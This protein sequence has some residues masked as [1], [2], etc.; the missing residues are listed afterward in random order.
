MTGKDEYYNKAK[1]E[2]YRARSAYKLKQLDEEAGLFGP[3]NTVVDL[4]AAPGGWL[5][6]ASEAVGERGTVVGV[7]FQRI[8]D[9]GLEN[10]ETIRGDM[11]DEDTKAELKE[12]IGEDGADVVVSDM[13]PNMTG[14]Y[15]LDHARSVHLARQ[16]FEVA[17]D[18]LPAGGDFAAKVFDGQ[19][20]DDLR[21]DVDAEFEYVRSIHP[22]A[23]RDSSS[24]LYLVGKHRITAPVREG[25]ER[26][27]VVDDVGSEGDGVVKIDGYTLF[28]PGTETGDAVRVRVTDVKAKFGFAEVVAE[29]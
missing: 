24:E 16:A 17:L 2:G 8:R 3:G 13:A 18:L 23:S 5:Q 26:D 4:G 10:V 9:L 12:K 20:L 22:D 6:V 19:D 1:Q 28:V 27:V 21:A 14:E 7:D 29:E 25:D 11:T 15:S